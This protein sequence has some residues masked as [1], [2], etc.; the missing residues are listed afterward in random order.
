MVSIPSGCFSASGYFSSSPDSIL[1]SRFPSSPMK[2][3]GAYAIATAMS[4]P[5]DPLFG[6]A[7]GGVFAYHRSDGDDRDHREV[8]PEI[9][10]PGC[11]TLHRCTA[12]FRRDKIHDGDVTIRRCSRKPPSPSLAIQSLGTAAHRC[13]DRGGWRPSYAASA[14]QQAVSRRFDGGGWAASMVGLL[15]GARVD[16]GSDGLQFQLPAFF[17]FAFPQK[18]DFNFALFALVLPQLPMTLG[19]AVLAYTDLSREYFGADSSKVTNRKVCLSMALANFAS[20]ALGWNASVPWCRRLGGALSFR[21]PDGGFQSDD[22][23][24]FH[25][26][27]AHFRKGYCRR[28]Q[29]AACSP[30]WVSCWFLPVRN[31]RLR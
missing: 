4:A 5:P 8:Y 24:H 22:R 26:F 17:P 23:A 12:D 7:D 9:G 30:F 28:L 13:V 1:V 15:F 25:R 27:G 19:N 18:V 29:S 10:H 11:A 6:A 31:W 21:R 2:V 3:I 20:F 14:G 16:L